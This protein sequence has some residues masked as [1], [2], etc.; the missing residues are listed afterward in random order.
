METPDNPLVL[1]ETLQ[2]IKPSA[3]WQTKLLIEISKNKQQKAEEPEQ[4]K[5]LMLFV[6]LLTINLFSIAAYIF[7]PAAHHSSHELNSFE[8]INSNFLISRH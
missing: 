3:D 8:E 7:I 4:R 1:F 2:S 6:I 5:L